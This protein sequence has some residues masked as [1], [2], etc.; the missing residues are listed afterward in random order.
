LRP[1]IPATEDFDKSFA[2]TFAI[3]EFSAI[4]GGYHMVAG[5]LLSVLASVRE[6][7]E[8]TAALLLSNTLLLDNLRDATTNEQALEVVESAVLAANSE[9]LEERIAL[10]QQ[11]KES[12]AA[13]AKLS[14]IESRLHTAEQQRDTHNAQAQRTKEAAEQAESAKTKLQRELTDTSSRLQQYENQVAELRKGIT[15]LQKQSDDVAGTLAKTEKANV[16]L[17]TALFAVLALIV[18]AA[19]EFSLHHF[20]ITTVLSHSN[21]YGIRATGAATV[22]GFLLG[23]PQKKHRTFLWGGCVV[24][25]ILGLLGLLGGPAK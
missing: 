1:Y 21:S 24:S 13:A 14:Q 8:E 20:Q 6:V 10:Q 11:L 17:K 2:E 23:I 16:R 18:I 7:K 22:L 4:S 12:R 19:A 3:P 25:A 9:L 5:R 15:S